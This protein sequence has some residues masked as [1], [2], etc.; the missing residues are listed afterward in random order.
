MASVQG[1]DEHRH[2]SRAFASRLID[3]LRVDPFAKAE[4]KPPSTPVAFFFWALRGAYPMM[5]LAS[6]LS[7][8]VGISEPFGAYILGQIIETLQ[9]SLVTGDYSA[10][11]AMIV[12]WVFGYFLVVR[13]VLVAGNMWFTSRELVPSIQPL[14][15]S[16]LN[17]W[18]LGLSLDYF[19][20]DFAG[21]LAQKQV[22]TARA[23]TDLVSEIVNTAVYALATVMGTAVLLIL[24]DPILIA[25][26]AT[27]MILYGFV[28]RYFMPRIRTRS[29]ARAGARAAVS[30]QV[31]DAITNIKTVKTYAQDG[32]EDAE[33]RHAL[34]RFRDRA[35]D[36]G[37][38]SALFR[39]VLVSVSGLLPV[40][41]IAMISYLV[42][43]G[44][45]SI[46]DLTA[47]GAISLRLAQMVGWVSQVI[48]A[49]F[50]N[51]GEIED[52]AQ[53]LCRDVRLALPKSPQV[54]FAAGPI[55]L[56]DV[57]FS[58]GGRASKLGPM[59]LEIAENEKLGIV[60][61]S[62]A[63]KTTFI[64]L[65]M[66]LYDLEKGVISIGARDISHMDERALRQ[67]IA[68]VAQDISLF[69]RSALDNIR[70]A[71][72][73]ATIEEVEDALRRASAYEFVMSLKDQQGREGLD[74]HLGERGVRLSGGQ[75]QRISIA[76]A[77]LKDAP[78]LILDEA[79]SALDS[80]IEQKIQL[81]LDHLMQ[82]RTVLAIAHRLSTLS[83]MD[84]IIVLDQGQLRESGTHD[85]LLTDNGI[86]AN[87]WQRQSGG[88][89]RADKKRWEL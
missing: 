21:R 9:V 24:I 70:Y 44:Q 84:R 20:N 2:H 75:R 12:I 48:M 72:P 38:T 19:E 53:T 30:G 86:Y 32:Y 77:I 52:G 3:P 59:S 28:L 5:I 55:V 46:G 40:S 23:V 64:S 63:G 16:R 79:T 49:M 62:G 87:Y 1:N 89:I 7:L 18:M 29:K 54:S 50:S 81:S 17:R 68:L 33:T 34:S 26:L 69:S 80:E 65:L 8:L 71:R 10:V 39:L 56:R 51:I 42:S 45:A 36:F 13:P 88:F 85:S 82:G 60:G 43:Q 73:D 78:I 67:N 27:W 22:Q 15:I 4:G 31:V 47:A 66:R 6:I 25:F 74:A 41:L 37:A 35:Q 58:Y 57:E 76:R 14:V 83:S 61:A 11:S